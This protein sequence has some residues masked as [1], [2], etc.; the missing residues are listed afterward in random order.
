MLRRKV[1]ELEGV[2]TMM[3]RKVTELQEKLTAKSTSSTRRELL[4]ETEPTKSNNIY[5][6]K[7]KVTNSKSFKLIYAVLFCRQT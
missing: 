1:E 4:H 7:I 6:R 2:E 5:D 3:K